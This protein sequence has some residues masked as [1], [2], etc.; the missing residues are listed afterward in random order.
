MEVFGNNVIV[1]LSYYDGQKC[2]FFPT[3][4]QLGEK[5]AIDNN[6]VRIKDAE[7]NNI[8]GYLDPDKR[9]IR[10]M[11]LRGEKSEG[12]LMPI[13]TLAPYTDVSQLQVGDKINV[14]NG[15]VIC[16]KY[17]PR[18]KNI[19]GTSHNIS[20]KSKQHKSVQYPLFKEHVDTEQLMYN[21]GAFKEGDTIYLTRKL[22]GTSFRIGNTLQ[23]QTKKR[24]LFL[25]K[26]FHLQ[27]K[28]IKTF[29]VIS[30]TRRTI[31]DTFE[32]GYYDSNQFRKPY[33]DFLANKLPKGMT[34]YGEI[35]GWMNETT[36]IMGKCS[37]L[38]V[39]DTAFRKKYGD[40]TVFAYGCKPGENTAYIYRITMQN[41]DGDT[42]ELP[43]EEVITW[44]E[45]LGIPYV[46]L[47]EKF[48]Y[49]TWNDLLA[50]VN[51]Y[52][53][54]PEPLSHNT[55]ISEGVVVRIDNRSKFTA[56]KQKGFYFKVLEGIISDNALY[57]NI[58]EMEEL[59]NDT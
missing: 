12:L 15:Q 10:A 35:V 19:T 49:T 37:N 56:Y 3:D 1:D 5:Y 36:P 53:D 17:I 7:G 27:D 38:K 51:Q 52:L 22:H 50:R 2:I 32:G 59:L 44:C 9:N 21:K 14:L 29:K 20:K 48:L 41:E 23:T 47:L 18:K 57:P 16:Q 45:K 33:Q 43:T 39:Q 54:L 40:E 24:K 42:I 30:G 8:G 13:E 46:P 26:I 25:R 55:H 58:E 11:K 34:V 4:G 28:E 31:L 6:L